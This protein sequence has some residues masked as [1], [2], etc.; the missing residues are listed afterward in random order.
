MIDSGSHTPE[1]LARRRLL[2]EQLMMGAAKPRQIEHWTQGAA[3]MAEALM[4]GLIARRAGEEDKALRGNANEMI[5]AWI[6]G[7]PQAATPAPNV[8]DA[9]ASIESGGKYD[10]LGPVTKTGDRA[11]GKY[12]VMGEN[13]PQWTRAYAGG[14]MTPQQFLA[15]PKAQDAVFKGEFGRLSA[16]HGPEG[17]ARAWF[18][19]EGGMNDPNR[20]DQLGTSVAQYGQKFA[21]AL[22]PQTDAP[23]PGMNRE[24]LVKMLNNPY[25]APMAQEIV[26]QQIARDMNPGKPEFGVI[27]EDEYGKKNYGWIDPKT[28]SVT[29]MRA[30]AA[31]PSRGANAPAV[32]AIPEPP[33]GADPKKWRETF[34][35]EAAERVAG[36]PQAKARAQ[37]AIANMFKTG[38]EALRLAGH[39]GLNAAVGP[40]S[41]WLPTF[42]DDTANFEADVATLG[43]RIFINTINRMRELSK[44]GGAVGSVTEKEM[45]KLENALKSLA[46][47]QGEGNMRKNLRGI[48]R[49]FNDSM[50]I[51][52]DAYKNQYGEELPFQGLE[53]PDEAPEDGDLEALLKKHG[54]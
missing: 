28:R 29:P 43:T 15:D 23:Q 35:K 18:A 31:A 5:A 9:I 24:A 46:L 26:K 48:A 53:V 27:G 16:K 42:R 11:Y 20:K 7:Q 14:E 52:S 6:G 33:P 25:T 51:I 36:A 12:Q 1:T 54:A 10:A 13:I 3:Q 21:Q 30:P 4:G 2:G 17:A 38:Q 41:G 37:D 22:G 47:T 32:D 34:T 45:M 19:G 49:E 39:K 40:I 44:T 8:G 50:K